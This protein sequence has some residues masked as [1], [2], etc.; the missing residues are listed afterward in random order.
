VAR[1][2][3]A[4]GP[5]QTAARL[6]RC[7]VGG[8]TVQSSSSSASSSCSTTSVVVVDAVVRGVGSTV[9]HRLLQHH[10]AHSPTPTTDW[11]ADSGASNHTTPYLGSISSPPPLAFHPH[12]IIVGNGSILPVT[13]VG[14][15]VLPGPLYLNDVLVAPDLVQSLLFVRCFTTDNSCSME[16]DPFGLSVKDLATRSVIAR[17]DSSGPLYTIPLSASATFSTDAPPYALAAATLTS[18]WHCRLGHPGPNVLSQLSRSSVIICPRVSSESLCH[19]CQLGR[20]FR[21][22]FPSSSSR[23]VRAFDLIHCD[24]ST[25][26]VPSVSGYKYYLVILDDCTHYLVDLSATP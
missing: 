15:S 12:S 19:A 25:S 18:T 1:P 6:L 22:P 23:A 14:D 20:H 17:Y 5:V 13:S 10:R 8:T 9:P 24:L 21:L 3:Q 2:V 7:T 11:V 16:F 4:N 26:I